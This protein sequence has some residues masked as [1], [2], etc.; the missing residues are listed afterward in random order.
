MLTVAF[1]RDLVRTSQ[2]LRS[3]HLPNKAASRDLLHQILLR[4]EV[5]GYPSFY[6]PAWLIFRWGYG[7]VLRCSHGLAWTRLSCAAA[8]GVLGMMHGYIS[9]DPGHW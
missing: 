5:G 7:A 9:D 6:G 1:V 3:R 4:M 2:K 8:A